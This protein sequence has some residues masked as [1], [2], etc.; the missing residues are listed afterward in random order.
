MPLLAGCRDGQGPSKV[1]EMNT[2][3][4]LENRGELS[5]VQVAQAALVLWPLSQPTLRIAATATLAD[6]TLTDHEA[7]R[8][9]WVVPV[10]VHL[11]EPRRSNSWN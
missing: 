9:N 8:L 11:S 6:R 2:P 5:H 7:F 1:A 3:Y 4:G 10:R